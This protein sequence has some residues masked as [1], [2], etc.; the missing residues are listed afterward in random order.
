MTYAQRTQTRS[1]SILLPILL[2]LAVAASFAGGVLVGGPIL[3]LSIDPPATAVSAGVLNAGRA[4]TLERE[5][6][7]PMRI[8]D[9]PGHLYRTSPAM[10]QYGHD[11][12]TRQAQLSGQGD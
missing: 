1:S 12:E 4:W 6:Q 9:S 3:R 8:W 7:I 10:V 11:W 5:Q 2:L